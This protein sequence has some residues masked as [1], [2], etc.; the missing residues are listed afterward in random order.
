[1][2]LR[3]TECPLCSKDTSGQLPLNISLMSNGNHNPKWGET[4]NLSCE[5]CE[6]HL[7]FFL[8]LHAWSTKNY[9]QAKK[10]RWI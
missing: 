6:E 5:P 2:S 9:E 10:N 1:M 8:A 7:G 3:E 4:F